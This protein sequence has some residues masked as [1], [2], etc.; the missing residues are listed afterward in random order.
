[1]RK[2]DVSIITDAVDKLVYD[3]AITV[4]FDVLRA[5][6]N[7]RKNEK[8]FRARKALDVI[9]EN[10]RIAG[11][12]KIPICQ[13]TGMTVVYCE[14]GRNVFFRG[15]IDKAIN[16]GVELATKRGYLRRSIVADPI[17]RENTGTNVPAIIHYKWRNGDKVKLSV[18][19]KGFGCENKGQTVMLN[20]TASV[21]DIESEV[22]RI[23]NE[24]GAHACPPYIIGVGLGGTMDKA[25]EMSKEVLLDPIG[26]RNKDSEYA[27]I[28]KR[29][30]KKANQLK[31]GALGLG[32]NVTTVL[33]VKIKTYATHI[34]GLPLAVNVS[35][36]ALRSKAVLV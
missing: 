19:L 16:K 18:L 6:E 21:D 34:A 27:A 25:C 22:I 36:H 17:K 26:R 11:A 23:I 30:I 15:N 24:A 32:G 4:R 1:M 29:L 7:V 31:I 8:S 5:L 12:K 3:A 20:P 9:I 33:D 10:T 28:E 2:I 13:D 35:C 14:I